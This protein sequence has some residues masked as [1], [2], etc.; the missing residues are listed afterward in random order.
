MLARVPELCTVRF[1]GDHDLKVTLK[2]SPSDWEKE[3]I[4]GLVIRTYSHRHRQLVH[5][6]SLLRTLV[7]LHPNDL[8]STSAHPVLV[9]YWL[10]AV[11]YDGV[12]VAEDL[13]DQAF[14]R[15]GYDWRHG[16]PGR[17]ILDED[18]AWGVLDSWRDVEDIGL[19]SVGQAAQA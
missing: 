8:D 13:M 4:R 9:S 19:R 17:D 14:R 16:E 6:R 18:I 5:I 1:C 10:H 15:V 12:Q 3:G 7:E 11:A 2:S